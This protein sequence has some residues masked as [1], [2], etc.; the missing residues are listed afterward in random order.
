MCL[1][2]HLKTSDNNIVCL[3]V[4]VFYLCRTTNLQ[5]EIYTHDSITLCTFIN[6]N[7]T[8][9]CYL[10]CTYR[11]R[12]CTCSSLFVKGLFLEYRNDIKAFQNNSF[13]FDKAKGWLS[14]HIIYYRKY[15]HH[16][17]RATIDSHNR[18]ISFLC[19]ELLRVSLHVVTCTCVR[20][21]C[22]LWRVSKQNVDETLCVLRTRIAAAVLVRVARS[23]KKHSTLSKAWAVPLSD[24]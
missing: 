12:T 2:R 21:S 6:R 17:T 22:S 9:V 4:F 10:H 15:V 13:S 3:I 5:S 16:Y 11:K 20:L 7:A 18:L 24:E 1:R 23:S 8:N 19:E 14:E